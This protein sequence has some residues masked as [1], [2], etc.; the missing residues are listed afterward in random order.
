MTTQLPER[1][2][3]LADEAPGALSG[4]ELWR[5]GR[6][7]HRTRVAT[8][9]ALVGAFAL[10]AVLVGLGDWQSRRP[11]PAA[12]PATKSGPMSIP[13]RFFTPGPWLPSTRTPGRLVAVILGA[14]Q[15][16]VVGGPT[17][18][19]VGV[20]AGSQ[21]YSF[22]DLPDH[23]TGGVSPPSL[24]PDGRHLA[25]VYDGGVPSTP[26]KESDARGLAVLD[27]MSGQLSLHAIPSP[28]GLNNVALRWASK[29][30]LVVNAT[31]RYDD[32][33]GH[34]GGIYRGVTSVCDE[35][36]SCRPGPN[37]LSSQENDAVAGGSGYAYL[38]T[39]HRVAVVDPSTGLRQASVKVRQALEYGGALTARRSGL[40]AQTGSNSPSPLGTGLVRHGRVALHHVPGTRSYFAVLGM[41]DSRHV[42][43]VAALRNRDELRSIALVTG[44]TRVLSTLESQVSFASDALVDPQPVAAIEPPRPWNRRAELIVLLGLVVLG[45]VALLVARLRRARR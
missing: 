26:L 19:V 23:D 27:L 20:A 34:V 13:D 4:T 1:L 8:S 37:N 2:R 38:D 44:R 33:S 18:G 28:Y 30:I 24:A 14:G 22:L 17:T 12:P 32:P 41:P 29:S 5:A 9:L 35:R 11:D 15:R 40:T 31:A 21:H 3:A 39:E 42:L 6:R 10:A 16:H 36:A 43:A 7:R 25:Y 45:G